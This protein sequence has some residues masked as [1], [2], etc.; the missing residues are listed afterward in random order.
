MRAASVHLGNEN[1]RDSAIPFLCASAPL[2]EALSTTNT[3]VRHKDGQIAWTEFN[4]VRKTTYAYGVNADGSRWTKTYE[5]SLAENSPV[6]TCSTS[7]P[8]G[9]TIRE[10]RP[11]YDGAILVT[12]NTYN[13]AGQLL[14]TTQSTIIGSVPS[15]LSVDLYS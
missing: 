10:E 2:R 14:A 6:W 1:H 12:E 3:T 11:G 9:R 7:D 15:V 4:G 8:L 13:A 5:G